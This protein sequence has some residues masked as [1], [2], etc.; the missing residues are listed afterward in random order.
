[1]NILELCLSRGFGGLEL[2]ASKVATKLQNT[3]HNIHVIVRQGTFLDEKLGSAGVE[4]DYLQ[5]ISHYFPFIAAWR[6]KRYVERKQIDVLHIH[7]GHDLFLAV[8]AKVLCRRQIKIVYTRQMALTRRKYDPYHRFLYRHIDVYLVITK[9]LSKQVEKYLPLDPTRVRVLYYGVPSGTVETVDC[10][11]Y[12]DKH[13]INNSSFKL[14]IFGRIEEGKGQ[15]LVLEALRQLVAEDRDLEL[16]IIG[17]VMDEAYFS[18]LESMSKES[19]LKNNI[20]FLGFHDK[21]VSIMPCFDVVVL[22][23]RCETFGLVLPEAMRAGVAVLGS[24]CGGVPEIIENEKTGLLFETGNADD[25]AR[26]LGKLVDDPEF[27]RRLAMSGK[28]DADQRFSEETH[29]R[30]L[31]NIIETTSAN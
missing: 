4:R 19:G 12:L 3:G 7:W 16:A 28:N 8:L 21:P 11:D 24:N 30:E 18:K 27:C 17:H 1:M 26:Q 15:H 5:S 14:A 2:Y 20:H 31:L 10:T 13:N 9:Q 25:L 23:S 29:F 22:A 6:L